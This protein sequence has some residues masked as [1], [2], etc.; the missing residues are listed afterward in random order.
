MLKYNGAI[1]LGEGY[2]YMKRFCSVLLIVCLLAV[3]PSAFAARYSS[4]ISGVMS[5]F[6][7]NNYSC[8]S[9]P[10]QQVNGTYRTVELLEL[11]ALK[12]GCSSSSVSSIM[13][14]FSI[15]NYSCKSAPQQVVNGTYR[16]VELLE[17]IALKVGAPSSSVSSIMSSYTIN[18]YS[19]DSAAQQAVNGTYRTVELLELI[20][21]NW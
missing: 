3:C 8:D 9:A 20:A 18:N 15:N 13:S 21:L 11:I 14:S 12:L 6:V 4:D 7:I 17:L 19:C 2:F 1:K 5:D 16:T 10:Q